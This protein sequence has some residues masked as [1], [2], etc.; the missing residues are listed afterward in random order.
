MPIVRSLP[1]NSL[2]ETLENTRAAVLAYH[3]RR[4]VSLANAETPGE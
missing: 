1:R 2:R 3:D 4:S